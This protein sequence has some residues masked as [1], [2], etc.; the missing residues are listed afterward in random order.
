MGDLDIR[1][2]TR[3][4]TMRMPRSRGAA[5]GS[6]LVLLGLWGALIP[7]PGPYVNFAFTPNRGRHTEPAH[8]KGVEPVAE[9]EVSEGVALPRCRRLSDLFRRRHTTSAR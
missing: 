9:S 6:L 7:F 1:I 2:R 8:S 5:T 4:V 3:G